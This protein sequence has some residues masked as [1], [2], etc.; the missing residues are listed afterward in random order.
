MTLVSSWS[1]PL[2][3]PF[4]LKVTET[5]LNCFKL[6]FC[7]NS[8]VI[9]NIIITVIS[10]AT[11]WQERQADSRRTG[12]WSWK[13]VT[14]VTL[15]RYLTISLGSHDLSFCFSL[16]A[17]F[18]FFRQ[19]ICPYFSLAK[20]ATLQVSGTHGKTMPEITK[21]LYLYFPIINSQERESDWSSL[22]HVP[23]SG[24]FSYGHGIRTWLPRYIIRGSVLIE[25][26]LW[27]EQTLQKELVRTTVASTIFIEPCLPV[28]PS[29]LRRRL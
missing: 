21:H 14:K 3:R 11:R 19:I 27:P 28:S 12:R 20:M 15:S 5:H 1:L 25:K 7:D 8:T 24:P 29:I 2:V 16:H 6:V 17:S 4:W 26:K 18:I 23:I 10:C 22:G 9:L 13:A